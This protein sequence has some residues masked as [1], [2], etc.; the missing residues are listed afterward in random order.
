LAW[1]SGRCGAAATA[2]GETVREGDVVTLTL[3][4]SGGGM[5]ARCRVLER[6][7]RAGQSLISLKLQWFRP[8]EE[9]PADLLARQPQQPVVKPQSRDV[10]RSLA[11]ASSSAGTSTSGFSGTV[12]NN[13]TVNVSVTSRGGA[14][15]YV[16]DHGADP[17]GTRD[18]YA[19]IMRTLDKCRSFRIPLL[20]GNGTYLWNTKIVADFDLLIRGNR[21]GTTWGAN[22]ALDAM[23]EFRATGSRIFGGGIE[24]IN[25]ISTAAQASDTALV[26]VD[27][28]H[29]FTMRDVFAQGFHLAVRL[30]SNEFGNS[31]AITIENVENFA[32]DLGGG[33]VRRPY[34]V[35]KAIAGTDGTVSDSKIISARCEGG[36]GWNVEL[37]DVHRFR[38][39]DP[40][41]SSLT[42]NI[43]GNVWIHNNSGAAGAYAN[44]GG[45]TIENPHLEDDW[46]D[47]AHVN[48]VNVLI[49][50]DTN[51]AARLLHNCRV[52]AMQTSNTSR[53][54]AKL[55]NSGSQAFTNRYNEVIALDHSGS[56]VGWV[57]VGA[58]VY[59]AIITAPH[60]D[61]SIFTT[62][63]NA[64]TS[65][66]IN[67]TLLDYPGAGSVPAD[68]NLDL[69][70]LTTNGDDS[71][72]YTV[73]RLGAT[74]ELMTADVAIAKSLVDAKGDLI[75]ATADNTPAR[76]AVGTN[77]YALVADS[78]ATPGVKW[79]RRGTAYVI[80][81]GR[82]SVDGT[83]T[84]T[85][86]ISLTVTD[87][88]ALGDVVLTPST[89]L[90]A[91]KYLYVS[92]VDNTAHTFTVKTD[93]NPGGT[94][95][96]TW[97]VLKNV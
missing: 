35:V 57:T 14:G 48:A 9:L 67:R 76:L 60:A 77:E 88:I 33:T 43:L 71:R 8:S 65:T 16:D 83:S 37:N 6:S 66:A 73:D 93:A 20:F 29:G 2:H 89:Y 75:V 44:T 32:Y 81:R 11:A 53:I 95:Q 13:S 17:T 15:I 46:V 45:H 68:A 42:N 92:A 85:F 96:I 27:S 49:D 90:G 78:A 21:R 54:L 61:K 10:I 55:A 58:N 56:Y 36:T 28:A 26:K 5:T 31:E 82:T 80:D 63:A 7:W 40:Y 94:I 52:I 23:I 41:M 62:V 3:P 4:R 86:T 25:A 12:V 59:R 18:S 1:A 79:A 22:V 30:T 72:L 87:T 24:D 70:Y 64:G 69:N 84:D 91:A 38:V 50:A 51:T 97:A 19:A 34:G 39:L 47:G 74:R